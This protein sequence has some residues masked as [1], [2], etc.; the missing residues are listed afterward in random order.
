MNEEE[1]CNT[2]LGLGIGVEIK[3][4]KQ[5]KNKKRGF[6][7]DLSLPLHPKIKASDM[8]DHDEK[9]DQ[10]SFSSKTIDDQEEEERSI[11]HSGSN[12]NVGINNNDGSRKKLKLTTEQT[13]L[14]EDSFKIHSTLN[15]G[16]K[17]ELAK[18]LNLLPRQIE[19]WFQNR[20]ART[21]L[22]Q[23]EK[24]CELLKKCCETL[25]DENLRLKK[26]LQEVRCSLKFDHHHHQ[27]APP[28]FLRH[29]TTTKMHHPCDKIGEEK[30]PFGVVNG[31]NMDVCDNSNKKNATAAKL[32]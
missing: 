7:L 11:K 25:N 26:E 12:G 3:R 2:T 29:P 24:E 17:Q 21:K 14:L 1:R 19:V 20:R 15:T 28:F 5:S 32:L 22:K 23:I 9:D 16:Q 31:G 8:N 27:P 4:E 18:K 10:D 30:K 6:W 13:V